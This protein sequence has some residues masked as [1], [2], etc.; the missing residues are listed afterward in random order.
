MVML[1][2]GESPNSE[3]LLLLLV[4]LLLLPLLLFEVVCFMEC[5]DTLNFKPHYTRDPN[6][7]KFFDNRQPTM[8]TLRFQGINSLGFG[9]Q[10]L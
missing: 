2:S 8:Q 5:L 4:V 3:N 1:W 6:G 9:A 7:D 10:I